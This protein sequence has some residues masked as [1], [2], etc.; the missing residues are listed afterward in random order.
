MKKRLMQQVKVMAVGVVLSLGAVDATAADL[1]VP[2]SQQLADNTIVAVVNDD[3]LLQS[4]VSL[5]I[6]QAKQQ[7]AAAGVKLP[8]DAELK[9]NV[10]QQLIYQKLQLQ[11]AKRA[12]IS[13]TNKEVTAAISNIA[14]RQNITVAELKQKVESQGMSY[15]DFTHNIKQQVLVS[16]VQ[17]QVVGQGL[18]VSTKDI[19]SA[20]AALE[21]NANASVQYDILDVLIPLPS[22]ATA[23]QQANA[24]AQ[25]KAIMQQLKQGV[26][27][28]DIKGGEV[29]AMGWRSTNKIPG[30]FVNSLS[31]L[32]VN[33]VSQPITAPNGLHVI[34]LLGKKG[35]DV[36]ITADQAR[37]FAYE[38]NFNKALAAWLKKLYKQSYIQIM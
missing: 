22:A 30:L 20:R 10:L 28:D 32:G 15:E 19:A 1:P 11:L 21:A 5:A 18:T 34:K 25:A 27:A 33:D 38:R 24:E 37:Q 6:R 13:V 29:N 26:T 3:V 17:H 36:T 14:K 16:K 35:N 8:S 31:T 7:A 2:S 12:Q 23:E 4:D 9:K